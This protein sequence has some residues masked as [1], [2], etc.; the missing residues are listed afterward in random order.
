M[1]SQYIPAGRTSVVKKGKAEFQLQT[2]YAGIPHPRVT[3]TIFAD[4]RVLHKV[5]K[6]IAKVIESI[7]EMH[8]IEEIINAQHMDVSR[9]IREQG[10]PTMPDSI[11]GEVQKK[12]RLEQMRGLPEVERVFLVSSEGKLVGDR[13]V[14]QEF[15]KMFKHVLR[16]L[17][18]LINVFEELPDGEAREEGIY[19]IE[20]GRIMLASTGVEFYLI[21]TAPRTPYQPFADKLKNI[22]AL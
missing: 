13:Q 16:E 19:E 11:A 2:E 17:P 10:L 18:E 21:L 1:A 3:T 15:K 7:D 4:G 20:R 5:E 8:Q 6:Q 9:T 14:T 12:T 22:L